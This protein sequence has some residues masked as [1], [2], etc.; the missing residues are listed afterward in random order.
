VIRK[1]FIKRRTPTLF[2]KA[3][4]NIR[5]PEVRVLAEHGEMVGIMSSV[6]AQQKAREAGKDLVLV[7]DKS[8]PPIVKIIELTKYKYQLQQREAENRKKSKTQDLKELQFSPFIGEGDFQTKMKRAYEFLERGDKVRLTVDFKSARNLAKKEFGY[9][10]LKRIFE[11]TAE[12]STIEIHPQLMGKKL[13]AQLMPVKKSKSKSVDQ[14][15][16]DTGHEEN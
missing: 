7:T 9:D 16:E 8:T 15:P 2:I 3:N 10:L 14:K 12:M 1:R 4:Y 11:L 5:F 6:E 13:M